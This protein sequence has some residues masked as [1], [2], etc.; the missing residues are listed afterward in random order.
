MGAGMSCGLRGPV[1][2]TVAA[3]KSLSELVADLTPLPQLHLLTLGF[4]NPSGLQWLHLF[5]GRM[6]SRCVSALALHPTDTTVHLEEAAPTAFF[7]A[8]VACA[9]ASA[10]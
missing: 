8:N 5:D 4:S 3:A 7:R 9:R 2:S 6:P 1:T 10:G